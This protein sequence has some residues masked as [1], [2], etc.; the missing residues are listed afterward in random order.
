MTLTVDNQ[1]ASSLLE[2]LFTE[3][4]GDLMR[5]FARRHGGEEGVQD[6]VQETFL[7]M[8]RGL[9]DG[10]SPKYARGYL[11]GIAREVLPIEGRAA[12]TNISEPCRPELSLS[13]TL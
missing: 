3:S 4:A 10:K 7:E 9:R 1:P 11:F 13:R 12:M 6:L 5:Y 8:A 2:R